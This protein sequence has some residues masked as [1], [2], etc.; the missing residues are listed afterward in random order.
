LETFALAQRDAYGL[1]P[2]P[3]DQGAYMLPL[4]YIEQA[5]NAEYEQWGWRILFFTSILSSLMGLF[6]ARM[7]FGSR[8]GPHP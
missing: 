8:E 7:C 6:V 2:S 4:E 3:G 5:S 1:L